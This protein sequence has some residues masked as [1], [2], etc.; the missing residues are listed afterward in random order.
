VLA[1]LVAA[2]VAMVAAPTAS[3]VNNGYFFLQRQG[4][5]LCLQVTS[6]SVGA[7][8]VQMPCQPPVN[9]NS[10]QGWSRYCLPGTG[11]CDQLRNRGSGLCLE[12]RNGAVNGGVVDMWPCNQISNENWAYPNYFNSILSRVSGTSTHCIDVPG[13]S[14]AN[15]LAVQLYRCNGT[16]AQSFTNPD[17][18]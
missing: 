9:P 16:N 2:A 6:H 15:G 4:A 3:A 5:D 11:D 13:G 17:L 10:D 1:L 12:A 8:V 7:S 18:V 14:F